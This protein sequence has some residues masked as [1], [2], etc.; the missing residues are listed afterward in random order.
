MEKC[1]EVKIALL[2]TDPDLL[3]HEL[4]NV[5]KKHFLF[6]RNLFCGNNRLT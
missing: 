2:F 3:T 6:L 4:F 5:K 1:L